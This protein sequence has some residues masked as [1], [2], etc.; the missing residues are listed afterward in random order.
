MVTKQLGL[1]GNAVL[2]GAAILVPAVRAQTPAMQRKIYTDKSAFKLPIQID[3][4][5]RA[6]IREV[7]LY[8]KAAPGGS[9]ALKETVQATQ[10]EFMFR[11]PK[12]GEYWF[13]VVAIDITGRPHPA[14]VNKEG[15]GL[16]VVVDKQPPEVD[17][18]AVPTASGQPCLRCEVRD[19]NP[20]P[21]KTKLEYEAPDQ[22]WKVIESM[23]DQPGLYLV[24]DWAKVRGVVRATAVDLAGNKTVKE[25]QLYPAGSQPAAP[26]AAPPVLNGGAPSLPVESQSNK[27]SSGITQA[28]YTSAR[29]LINSTRTLLKYNIEDQGPSGVGK[30]EVWMTKDE[31]QT[32]KLLCEDPKR[33]SP[34]AIDLPGEGVYGLSLVVANGNG[35]GG[36]P[37]AKGEAP[38]FRV[39]VDTTKP[40]ELLAVRSGTGAEA[41][42][43]LVTWNAS[44]KNL[45]SEPI[46]LY[47]SNNGKAPWTPIAKGLKNDGNHRWTVPPDASG[48]LYIRLDVSDDAGNISTCIAKQ[49]VMVD[50]F[51]PKGHIVGT[52]P[53][54]K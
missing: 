10:K 49:P 25:V 45:K 32:W 33:Q 34:V 41:G 27:M 24:P 43:V 30:V 53:G 44:D 35:S 6:R 38:D 15:P 3:E 54:E 31:G 37:P 8:V 19:S 39:E 21:S 11:A 42:M 9:W 17:V 40:A 46:D 22:S 20:D 29:Q 4:K 2:M 13:A 52:A 23:P 28:S 12:D 51:R 7:Q 18:Q 47:Y 16:I 36:T 50:V 26:A 1:W 5:E 14:D 48:K